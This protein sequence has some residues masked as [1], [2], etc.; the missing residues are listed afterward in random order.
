MKLVHILQLIASMK[1]TKVIEILRSKELDEN[2]EAKT[3]VTPMKKSGPKTNEQEPIVIEPTM[4][5][6]LEMFVNCD[7]KAI[8]EILQQETGASTFH[9]PESQ[10]GR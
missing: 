6:L 8:Q 2:R 3:V 4:M 1:F 7:D 5:A 9:K 10:T